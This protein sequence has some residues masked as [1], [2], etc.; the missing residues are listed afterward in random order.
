M[1][2]HEIKSL[3]LTQGFRWQLGSQN[4]KLGIDTGLSLIIRRVMPDLEIKNW[5]LTQ[6]YHWKLGQGWSQDQKLGS[7]TGLSLII[8]SWL[9]SKSKARFGCHFCTIQSRDLLWPSLLTLSLPLPWYHLKTTN[10]SAKS[11]TLKPFCLLFCTGMWKDFHQ[12]A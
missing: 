4:Q 1:A 8:M 9:I 3:V 6:G 5:V 2:D 11:E 12:N 7:D 10:E